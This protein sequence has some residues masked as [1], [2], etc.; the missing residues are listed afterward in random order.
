MNYKLI[1][2]YL[3]LGSHVMHGT[4][5]DDEINVDLMA[6]TLGKFEIIYVP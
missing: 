5:H 2:L 4:T 3:M 6:C 1:K